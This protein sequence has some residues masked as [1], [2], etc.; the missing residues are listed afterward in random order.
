VRK[1]E[2]REKT[3]NPQTCRVASFSHSPLDG[4]REAVEKRLEGVVGGKKRKGTHEELKQKELNLAVPSLS[5][6]RG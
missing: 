5:Q 4:D 2:I 1:K 3:P 6:T